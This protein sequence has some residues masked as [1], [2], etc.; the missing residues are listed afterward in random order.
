MLS[1]F[2]QIEIKNRTFS[3]TASFIRSIA[4]LLDR[5]DNPVEILTIGQSEEGRPIH[6]FRYGSGN[7]RV[8]LLAGAHSDEP[9]G[10]EMLRIL[11][12]HLL[13]RKAPSGLPEKYR[14]L[15]IPHI[16]PDGEAK[17]RRWAE[18]WPDLQA[19][20]AHAFREEPGRDLEFGYPGMRL[21]NK[22]VSGI[23]QEFAPCDLYINF[24]GMAFAE[25]IMLLIERHWAD[26]TNKLQAD[27]QALA[28][29][30]DL[31]LHDHDRKGEKGFQY[32]GPGFT[33]TPKGRAMR[34]HFLDQGDEV[35][36]SKFHLSSMEYIRSLGGDP[37]CLVT[38]LPLFLVSSDHKSDQPGV[39][40]TYLALKEKLPEI[41]RR[42]VAEKPLDPVL[43]NFQIKPVPIE[44]A[45]RIQLGV[46]RSALE[47][48]E[49]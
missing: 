17:N 12:E 19:Y 41:R 34:K 6:A 46:I 27:F 49:L 5:S 42:A 9:V 2:D 31:P 37:L 3:T 33:T 26:R 40:A 16:N 18:Q 43:S 29:K 28:K 44:T 20:A 15:I 47:Q 32:I 14:I 8:V 48:T 4:P 7:T 21:E 30:H 24:H 36:A 10:P 38:E 39:P 13:T 23:L 11:V 22:A 35:T 45:I 1:F 25:G